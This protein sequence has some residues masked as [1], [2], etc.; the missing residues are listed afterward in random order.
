MERK[1][2]V[3]AVVVMTVLGLPTLASA[4]AQK[5]PDLGKRE[6]PVFPIDPRIA[7]KSCSGMA[8][9]H[10]PAIE[11]MGDH[12][13]GERRMLHRHIG[14]ALAHRPMELLVTVPGSGQRQLAKIAGALPELAT[15]LR[16]VLT[17]KGKR[18][19]KALRRERD[20]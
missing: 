4:Q 15:W 13:V 3:A 10:A 11:Q 6:W 20:E 12:R 1:H 19:Q 7:H 2:V 17:R 5:A 8:D 18:Q 14:R 9:G 16:P